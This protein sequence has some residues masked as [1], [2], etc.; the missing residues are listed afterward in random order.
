MLPWE[1]SQRRPCLTVGR[2]S[3]RTMMGQIFPL[4]PYAGDVVSAQLG[5]WDLASEL[6]PGGAGSGP[7]RQL[8]H[9]PADD[10]DMFTDWASSGPNCVPCSG[11]VPRPASESVAM[12]T[13]SAHASVNPMPAALG[14]PAPALHAPEA[15]APA[16]QTSL[17]NFIDSL[18]LPYKSRSSPLPL[19]AAPPT[20]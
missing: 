6:L 9:N 5:A 20:G 15:A 14:S 19:Y 7:V 18:R 17:V 11:D 16:Q 3:M 1:D 8:C 10:V 2:P 12:T 13:D 4:D